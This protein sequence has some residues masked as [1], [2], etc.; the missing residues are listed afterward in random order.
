MATIV[1][2]PLYW[3]GNMNVTFALAKKLQSRG[4]SVHYACIPDMEER[5]RSQ[6]FDFVPVFS[7]VFPLGTLPAQFADEAKGKYLGVARVNTRVQAMCELCRDGGMA[8]STRSLHPDLFLVSNHMPWSAID[9]WKTG[10]PVV[11]FSSIIV[12]TPDS[13]APPI[14]SH[15]IPSP[16]LV[17]R[18]GIWWEWRKTMLRRKLLM[19]TSGWWK[20]S[21]SLK[22]LAVA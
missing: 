20:T 2:A 18:F 17:S 3:H 16:N 15:T 8:K 10:K 22:A 6:G 19:R 1:I 21:A 7:N 13:M 11:M 4:H 5:V 14:H 9:A 12:S